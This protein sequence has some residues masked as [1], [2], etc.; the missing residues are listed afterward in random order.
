MSSIAQRSIKRFINPPKV[1]G[2]DDR[3]GE[4]HAVESESRALGNSSGCPRLSRPT[5]VRTRC[6]KQSR[7]RPRRSTRLQPFQASPATAARTFSSGPGAPARA[8]HHSC[9]WQALVEPPRSLPSWA[10]TSNLIAVR[11]CCSSRTIRRS[12]APPRSNAP[13]CT[14]TE[15]RC[16]CPRCG[17]ARPL[18]D[19]ES[20][21]P[22]RCAPHP[23]RWES[24]FGARWAAS[25][26]R[27]RHLREDR[28]RWCAPVR[29]RMEG[30]GPPESRVGPQHIR[31]PPLRRCA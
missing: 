17:S 2:T 23:R 9:G 24:G 5:L 30:C 29:A 26:P 4:P 8:H 7:R 14:A 27:S 13:A 3:P 6:T 20:R 28:V 22:C 25:F 1:R 19:K 15:P 31:S 18:P 11:D 21:V 10:A 16:R 12:A